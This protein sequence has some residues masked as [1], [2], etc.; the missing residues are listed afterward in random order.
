LG[1]TNFSILE[2]LRLDS[3]GLGKGFD[4]DNLGQFTTMTLEV[5]NS[6]I[7][8]YDLVIPPKYIGVKDYLQD[9]KCSSQNASMV[10]N[11]RLLISLNLY[12]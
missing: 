8:L 10:R 4:G 1:R 7:M 5:M 2:Q 9:V 3:I 12:S 11:P 6:C